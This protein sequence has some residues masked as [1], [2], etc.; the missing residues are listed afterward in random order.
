MNFQPRM[1]TDEH[2]FFINTTSIMLVHEDITQQIL[3]V[4]FEVSNELGSGFL[5]NVYKRSL[6]IALNQR[7]LKA[8]SEVSAKVW[9]RGSIVGLF[10]VD[11]IV[12]E[13]IV[14]EVKAV[15]ALLQEHEAQLLNYLRATN[16]KVGL[17][18]NF[19]K[20]KIEWKRM[21]L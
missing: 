20:S 14:V 13:L 3:G 17:I 18:V 15:K 12:E 8:Q 2:G 5:E 10:Y 7:G 9:F 6:L 11:I 1:N 19:G 16:F 21:I 4:C